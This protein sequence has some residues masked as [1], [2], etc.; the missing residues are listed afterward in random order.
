MLLPSDISG[1]FVCKQILGHALA[2]SLSQENSQKHYV[3]VCELLAIC[4]G[5]RGGC[6][7]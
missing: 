3:V 5:V 6:D 4:G 2:I 1:T 7:L